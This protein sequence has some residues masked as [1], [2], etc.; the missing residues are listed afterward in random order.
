MCA[1]A[2][3]RAHWKAVMG[4]EPWSDRRYANAGKSSDA[5]ANY[6]SWNDA[7]EFCRKLS[8]K[9]GKQL[10]LPTEAEWE[11]A[12]RAGSTT[13][14]CFGDD[15]RKLGEYAWYEGNVKAAGEDY[16]HRVAQKK[17]NE[18]G[19]YDMH[20]NVWEWCQDWYGEDYYKQSPREDPKGPATSSMRIRVLRGGSW[21]GKPSYCRSAYR[22]ARGPSDT[23]F[24]NGFR[25]VCAAR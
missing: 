25:V 12:C 4:T 7:Q 23:Y 19:L 15:A 10:R 17:P 16:P 1:T 24:L 11:Y 22:N 9:V 20:G 6:V 2:V 8:A 21:L 3:T 13:E 14:Y 5:P 18:W